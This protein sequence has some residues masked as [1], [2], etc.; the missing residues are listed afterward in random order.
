MS[1]SPNYPDVGRG[2]RLFSCGFQ[3]GGVH[4][5][6]VQIVPRLPPFGDNPAYGFDQ[7]LGTPF[8]HPCRPGLIADR[9]PISAQPNWARRTVN[10]QTPVRSGRWTSNTCQSSCSVPAGSRHGQLPGR[11]CSRDLNAFLS[12]WMY[13]HFQ[14]APVGRTRPR[15]QRP[16]I[17]YVSTCASICG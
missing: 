12:A 6:V 14:I 2:Y 5:N 4:A 15:E 10:S 1:P 9:R 11:K 17:E 7:V 13:F 16:N 3:R 8:T